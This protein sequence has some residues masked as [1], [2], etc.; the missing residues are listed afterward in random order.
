SA[1][2]V[3][4]VKTDEPKALVSV[5]SMVNWSDHAAENTTGAVEKVYGMMAGF[6]AESADAS[7]AAAKFAMMGISPKAQKEKK[8]WEVKFEATLARFEK[9][10]ESS[11]N[12]NKLV[13]SSMS[14]RTKIGLGFKEY[15]G[16]DE[17]L[18][19]I[20]FRGKSISGDGVVLVD[21]LPDDE[22]VDPRVK[23]E[24]VSEFASSPPRSR[25]KHLGV[26]SDDFLWDKPVEDFFSSESE[27]VSPKIW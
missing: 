20:I 3:T 27:S 24:T 4:E 6:H 13:N 7:D 5:D 1:F 18:A 25:R 9:W 23:V 17:V 12:L 8:E 26:R 19:E 16:E 22:I 2:K 11:K 10:K 14:T 15:F 21:K